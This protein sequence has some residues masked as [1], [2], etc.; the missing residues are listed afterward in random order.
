MKARID[1]AGITKVHHFAASK[2]GRTY[3]SVSYRLRPVG[4]EVAGEIEM[5]GLIVVRKIWADFKAPIVQWADHYGVPV[6]III[7]TIATESRGKATA[8]RKEPGYRSDAA[9]PHRV[10]PGL[11]QTLI[12]TA[13]MALKDKS[14]NRTWLYNPSNSIKAG[15]AYIAQQS[16]RTGMDPPLSFAAYNAGGVYLQTGS[17]NRWK[18]RQYPIGTDEHVDRAID[19]FNACFAMWGKDGGA[20]EMS[21]VR[22]TGGPVAGEKTDTAETDDTSTNT[23][24]TK[25]SLTM[26]LKLIQI[27][28]PVIAAMFPGSS[29]DDKKS[30]NPI[31]NLFRS[32]TGF[33]GADTI[34]DDGG[35][36]GLIGQ[37]IP[38]LQGL[39][40][41]GEGLGDL[42]TGGSNGWLT[43]IA[44]VIQLIIGNMVMN[45]EKRTGSQVIA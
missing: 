43:L 37:F 11:M 27:A 41:G 29:D 23:E 1:L 7:A 4:F 12:S 8:L 17:A 18:T 42:L 40:E 45:E 13:R 5:D 39:T 3:K 26:W 14:I 15:T 24:T 36:Y 16:K 22:L 28:L 2:N 21:F 6:E 25:G 20:P 19:Y 10:S 33:F 34:A 44:F 35:L 9:T 32:I 38:A 30:N 31:V